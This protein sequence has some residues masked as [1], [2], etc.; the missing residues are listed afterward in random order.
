MH[1]HGV[2][3]QNGSRAVHFGSHRVVGSFVSVAVFALAVVVRVGASFHFLPSHGILL[4]AGGDGVDYHSLAVQFSNGSFIS[5]SLYVLRPP[6]FP[7]LLGSLF[8]VLGTS[9]PTISVGVSVVSSSLTAVLAMRLALLVG[10][11]R[12]RALFVGIAV[13]LDPTFVLIGIAPLSD[14]LFALACTSVAFF[15]VKARKERYATA[16]LA[17]LCLALVGAVLIKPSAALLW[18]IPCVALVHAKRVATAAIVAGIALT[19]I[20]AWTARNYVE[21]GIPTYSTT[22][23]YSLLFHRAAG[24]EVR[25]EGKDYQ[26]VVLPELEREMARRLRYSKVKGHWYYAAP[27]SSDV[28]SEELRLALHIISQHPVQ[29]LAATPV[30]LERLYFSSELVPSGTWQRLASAWYTVILV[31]AALKWPRIRRA[32]SFF[33]WL[34][35]AFLAY[36]SLTTVL[37]ITSGFG[38]TRLALPFLPL[39]FIAAAWDRSAGS[40]RS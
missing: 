26:N 10:L 5:P 31:F 20:V 29:Y 1:Q 7:W 34:V 40:E 27:Q 8:S 14:A 3:T 12:S 6:G 28:A 11:N 39:L 30:G 24:T 23:A 2:E 33:A 16:P 4:W 21:T 37:V 32:N 17:G 38:G 15:L 9:T 35:V 18:V 25:A 22:I 19:P 13:A 36:F